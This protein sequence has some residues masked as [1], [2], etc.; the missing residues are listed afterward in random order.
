MQKVSLNNVGTFGIDVQPPPGSPPLGIPPVVTA[1]DGVPVTVIGADAVRPGVYTLSE[2][3]PARDVTGFWS[4][5]EAYCDG[6]K[7][8]VTTTPPDAAHPNGTWQASYDIESPENTRCVLTNHFNP[9]GTLVVEKVTEGPAGND[10]G[11]FHFQITEHP[12][13]RPA[14]PSDM[15]LRATAITTSPDSPT[16]AH[17]D[18]QILGPAATGLHVDSALS[19]TVQELLPAPNEFGSWHLVSADCGGRPARVEP[20]TAAIE[21]RITPDQPH[22][23]CLFTNRF[24]AL[25]TLDVAKSSSDDSTLRPGA[26]LL[27]LICS[28]DTADRLTLAAA[29]LA[30]ALRQHAFAEDTTCT[31]GE[32]ATGAA[33]GVTVSTSATR[34]VDDGA[35]TPLELGSAFEVKAGT[36]TTIAVLNTLTKKTVPGDPDPG[37]STPPPTTTPPPPSKPTPTPTPPPAKPVPPAAKPRPWLPATGMDLRTAAS[38]ISL[39]VTGGVLLAA[40][41]K[42]RR[43]R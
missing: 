26:A 30:A 11:T 42:R 40:S 18:G 8:A 7:L 25:T 33:S 22:A 37:G 5:P 23:A 16:Q 9:A 36:H 24:V 43:V 10:T 12:A 15:T 14:R 6:K 19:Y 20:V 21:V 3:L 27:S 28:D 29:H 32:T 13:D 38:A 1:Q 35:P 31:V 41:L 2:D 4:L 17:P 39:T 34:T